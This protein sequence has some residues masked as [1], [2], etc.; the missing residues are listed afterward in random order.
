MIVY[1]ESNFV[2]ELAYLQ[3]EHESC[4][5]IL[6][7]AEGG[8]IILAIPA[9][10]VGEPYDSW[11]RRAKQRTELHERL[12]REI[13]ELARSKPY[14]KSPNEFQELTKTLIRSG[15]EEKQRLDDTIS[16]MLETTTVIPI[17]RDTIKAAIKLQKTRNLSPQDS[18]VYASVLSHLAGQTNEPK[19]FITKNS[20]DFANPDVDQDLDAYNCK[21]LTKFEHGLGY[22]KSQIASP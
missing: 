13:R 17:A 14:V 18:I 2:L 11:V 5:Q 7:L 9:Y 4:E 19:C 21:L 1:I 15:E 12:S 6:A 3:E 8:S 20:K 10:C 16:R 22:A